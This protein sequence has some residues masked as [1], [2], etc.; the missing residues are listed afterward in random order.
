MRGSPILQ[1][2]LVMVLF[3]ALWFAGMRLIGE[4]PQAPRQVKVAAVAPSDEVRVDVEIYFSEK[5]ERYVLR[6][7]VNGEAS[8]GYL[9]SAAGNDENPVLHE[10]TLHGEDDGRI[11]LDVIWPATSSSGERHFAQVIL[12]AGNVASKEFTFHGRQRQLHGTMEIALPHQG[13]Q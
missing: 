12:T 11:W 10:F 8:D 6:K 1:A 4:S 9:V 5:P 7:P 13:V 2:A 3:V